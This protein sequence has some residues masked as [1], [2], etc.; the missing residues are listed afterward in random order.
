MSCLRLANMQICV[1]GITNANPFSPLD[2]SNGKGAPVR[3]LFLS[4]SLEA[5][6]IQ[7]YSHC[8]PS[9]LSHISSNPQAIVQGLFSFFFFPSPPP[10]FLSSFYPGI[11]SPV[12]SLSSTR[13]RRKGD[14]MGYISNSFCSSP[15]S[16]VRTSAM[17]E[18][19]GGRRK[20]EEGETNEPFPSSS[21]IQ[22]V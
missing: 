15:P 1:S 11:L 2:L 8:L 22:L 6:Q 10:L 9:S 16:S 19:A 12:T 3:P 17:L 7:Q 18:R 14:G 20:R 13:R 5:F 21:S 4:V